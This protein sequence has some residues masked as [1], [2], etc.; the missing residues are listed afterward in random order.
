MSCRQPS[1]TGGRECHRFQSILRYQDK[2]RKWSVQMKYV[3]FLLCFEMPEVMNIHPFYSDFDT[4]EIVCLDLQD[5][6]K[7]IGNLFLILGRSAFIGI[8]FDDRSD[9]FDLNVALQ[10]HFK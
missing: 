9:S 1:R 10:D 8:G 7:I 6:I 5:F 4:C 3:F 2:R